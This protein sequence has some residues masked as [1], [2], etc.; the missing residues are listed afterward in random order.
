[1][2]LK[3]IM[4]VNPIMTLKMLTTIY[5]WKIF[6]WGK[7]DI[8]VLVCFY[9]EDYWNIFVQFL[10]KA[11]QL[12]VPLKTVSDLPKNWITSYPKYIKRMFALKVKMWRKWTYGRNAV[13]KRKYDRYAAKCKQAVEAL[14]QNVKSTW[15]TAIWSWKIL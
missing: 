5:N 15:L 13:D 12:Y 2:F 10:Y 14:M 9:V 1:M 8:W 11:I 3:E 7:L 6:V 4:E